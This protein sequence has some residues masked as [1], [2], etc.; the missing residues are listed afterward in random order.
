MTVVA[1]KAVDA[2]IGRIEDTLQARGLLAT[3]NIIVTSDHGFS[4]Q[5]GT[6]RLGPAVTGFSQAAPDGGRDIVVTEG[7]VNF[8]GPR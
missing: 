2:E 7:A 5:S 4:S 6:L 1:L 3:T 8:R